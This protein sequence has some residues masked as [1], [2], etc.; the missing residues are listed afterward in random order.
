MPFPN[1]A[2]GGLFLIQPAIRSP[3]YNAGVSGWTV[4]E[5]GSAEFTNI[6]ITATG[7]GG[8]RVVNSVDGSEVIITDGMVEFKA[9]TVIFAGYTAGIISG[10]GVGTQPAVSLTSPIRAASPGAVA[11]IELVAPDGVAPPELNIFCSG[12][13]AVVIGNLNDTTSLE[14]STIQIAQQSHVLVDVSD[15]RLL[16]QSDVFRCS[17]PLALAAGSNPIVGCDNIYGT[18][19]NIRAGARWK[20]TLTT[21]AQNGAVAGVTTIGELTVS[22][23]GGAFATQTG[24][25]LWRAGA[26]I[27]SGSMP[28]QTWKGTFAAG[29]FIE[30]KATGKCIGGGVNSFQATHTALSI[31]IYE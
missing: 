17:A 15:A 21:D 25:C 23:N 14:S 16:T 5:D 30:F 8:L 27:N 10:I 11:S 12:G 20:A 7:T 4:N 2:T 9:P 28:S 26:V 24:Q 22:E 31:D 13:G 6:T 29:G 18:V 19:N 1:D 3:N